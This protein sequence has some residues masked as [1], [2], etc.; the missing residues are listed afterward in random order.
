M[1]GEDNFCLLNLAITFSPLIIDMELQ[2]AFPQFVFSKKN[3]ELQSR[4]L[5]Q[6]VT[7]IS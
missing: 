2:H 7:L 3:P 4:S 5:R 1:F 6:T